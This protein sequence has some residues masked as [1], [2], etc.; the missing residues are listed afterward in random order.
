MY[1]GITSLGTDSLGGL[2]EEMDFEM[3]LSTIRMGDPKANATR[4]L[5]SSILGRGVLE[6]CGTKSDHQYRLQAM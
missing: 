2:A 1:R 3:G 4:F 6:A 5:R